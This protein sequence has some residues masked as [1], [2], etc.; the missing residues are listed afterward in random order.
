MKFSVIITAIL[1]LLLMG[2][3]HVVPS[4][5][6]SHCEVFSAR[7]VAQQFYNLRLNVDDGGLPDEQQLQMYRPYFSAALYHALQQAQKEQWAN[8]VAYPDDKPDFIDGDLF[9]SL[10][11]GISQAQVQEALTKTS[12]TLI[13]PVRLS[14]QQK[15]SEAAHWQDSVVMLKSGQCWKIDDIH[16]GGNWDFAPR[17]S[18]RALLA[19]RDD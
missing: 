18:L 19:K 1:L 13:L 9:S 17:G 11:E 2:C 3:K 5:P 8:R 10:F 14:Y 12:Y 15:G 4:L 7:E 16:Y 6:V